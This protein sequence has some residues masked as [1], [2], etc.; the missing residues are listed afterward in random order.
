MSPLIGHPL[1]HGLSHGLDFSSPHVLAWF[2]GLP[3]TYLFLAGL[4]RSLGWWNFR[5]KVMKNKKLQESTTRA[6]DDMAFEIV[7]GF[8][9]T[10]LAVAGFV[11]RYNLFGVDEYR[12]LEKDPF[13]GES[14]FVRNH[15]STPM[16]F[17]QLWNVVLCTQLEVL[18]D[19]A[20][21]GH[22]LVA[23]SLAYLS[24][25]PYMQGFAFFFLGIVEIT[26]IP[27]TLYDVCKKFSFKDGIVFAI[28]QGTFASSFIYI[29]LIVWFGWCLPFW[30][31]SIDL[32]RTGKAHNSA[33]VV[34]FLLSNIFMTGLQLFWGQQIIEGLLK[35][36]GFIKERRGGK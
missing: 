17:Y 25:S 18:N 7:A 10:Y 11:G 12:R 36:L 27:L 29:R 9:V 22:H 13:F 30:V 33:I 1:L 16:I 2:F 8:C 3:I 23:A 4:F 28:S 24:L 15:L 14:E 19:M 6:S 21:F 34:Y 35:L 20:M 31:G 26:S 32:L 5:L